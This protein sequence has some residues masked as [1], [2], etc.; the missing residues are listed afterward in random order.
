MITHINDGRSRAIRR[1]RFLWAAQNVGLVAFVLTTLL[2]A[3]GGLAVLVL[4]P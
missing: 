4:T 2:L 1:R 3:A